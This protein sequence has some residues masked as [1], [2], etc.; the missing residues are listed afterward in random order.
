MLNSDQYPKLVIVS[1]EH[2]AHWL[3]DLDLDRDTGDDDAFLDYL[4]NHLIKYRFENNSVDQKQVV[5]DLALDVLNDWLADPVGAA[6]GYELHNK[7]YASLQNLVG[8]CMGAIDTLGPPTPHE[9]P[10][11]YSHRRHNNIVLKRT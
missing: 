5:Q 9:L 2:I 10:Y 11:E 7:L 6:Y 1:G 4:L 3:E 8:A